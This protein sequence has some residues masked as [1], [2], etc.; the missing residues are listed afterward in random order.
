MLV[1]I[2]GKRPEVAPDAVLRGCTVRDGALV[3]MNSAVLGGAV[4]GEDGVV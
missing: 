2:D 4:V 3:G 1:E